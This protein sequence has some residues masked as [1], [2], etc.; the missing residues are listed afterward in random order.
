MPRMKPV[1]AVLLT[2][3]V[4]VELVATFAAQLEHDLAP[5][6][7]ML[8]ESGAHGIADGLDVVRRALAQRRREAK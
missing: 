6:A 3:C 5:V 8:L 1:D 7:L 4:A 2:A